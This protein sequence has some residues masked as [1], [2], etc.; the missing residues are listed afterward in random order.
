MYGLKRENKNI[1]L[2]I[3]GGLNSPPNI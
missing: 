1:Y 2:F 3:L